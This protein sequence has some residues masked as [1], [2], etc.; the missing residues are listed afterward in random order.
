MS[1]NEAPPFTIRTV[2]WQ[3][4]GSVLRTIRE[5]V[6]MQEQGVPPELEWDG[7]DED[8]MHALAEVGE[9]SVGCAR[10]LRDG[11]IG[12]IAVLPT[13]RGLGI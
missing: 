13:W 3:D 11:H 1:K 7:L 8:C 5:R 12:R 10:L 2:T 6:F 9:E 4:A